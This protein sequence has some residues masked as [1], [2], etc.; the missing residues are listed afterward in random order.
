MLRSFCADIIDTGV[1]GL[2]CIHPSSA[3][4][5][6]LS[7]ERHSG[8]TVGSELVSWRDELG[9]G[10]LGFNLLEWH[11]QLSE[12]G[13]F[14]ELTSHASAL[15]HL[16]Q[17]AYETSRRKAADAA[18]F[19]PTD[20]D[21]VMYGD[22][23]EFSILEGHSE[24]QQH[25]AQRTR[26]LRV[27]L[28]L[29]AYAHFEHIAIRTVAR[30]MEADPRTANLG[31]AQ[32]AFRRVQEALGSR[33]H[34]SDDLLERVGE[35]KSLRDE[36][37]HSGGW[38]RAETEG[39]LEALIQHGEIIIVEEDQ[40]QVLLLDESFVEGAFNDLYRATLAL[41]RAVGPLAWQLEGP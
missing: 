37:A 23:P 8:V 35:L 6:W 40:E 2:G 29:A 5:A 34:D 7:N 3:D 32:T 31:S 28:Y 18:K 25:L 16:V 21:G 12:A 20:E 38:V 24:D 15:D 30:K 26:V 17:D 41:L 36:L 22:S 33:Y 19:V 4:D 1:D 14:P 13:I 10:E 39:K 11:G 9:V 27:G